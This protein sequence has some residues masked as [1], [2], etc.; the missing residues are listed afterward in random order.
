MTVNLPYGDRVISLD[1]PSHFHVDILT[2]RNDVPVVD[3]AAFATLADR[4][5][6]TA[7]FQHPRPLVIV[8][9]GY[10]HTP[11]AMVL[12]FISRLAPRFVRQASFLMATGTHPAPTEEHLQLIF[13]RHL[14]AVRD[15]LFVHTATDTDSMTPVG[16]DQFDQPV[17]LNRLLF[18]FE[19]IVVIGSVEPHY[20]AGFTGGRKSI[21]PGLCDLGTTE[22][23]HNLA[24]SLS[25]APLVLNGNPVAEHLEAMLQLATL[26]PTLSIQ[27]VA[28][29]EGLPMAICMGDLQ[30]SFGDACRI[31]TDALAHR[32]VEPYDLAFACLRPP[33]DANL[34]QAQKGAENSLA[35]VRDQGDLVVISPCR[36]GIGSKHFMTEAANW[37]RAANAPR[38]GVRRF[39]SHK[40]SR[41]VAAQKRL[42]VSLRCELDDCTVEAAFYH[43]APDLQIIV[44]RQR[45]GCRV[46]LLPDAGNTA[47]YN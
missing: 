26:P 45:P 42:R 7:V 31:A 28:N 11:T 2:P 12:D 43:A 4:A 36:E 13:G 30:T 35:G 37:D 22:R 34:Y 27:V 3:T 33:L 39:G 18:A 29:H 41:M 10:R 17:H 38:D 20:F 15:R 46:A 24:A 6:A 25:A 19:Q 16:R 40:L 14:E 23:N 5:G 8:N 32:V 1:L 21:I 44:G 47:L 9:D